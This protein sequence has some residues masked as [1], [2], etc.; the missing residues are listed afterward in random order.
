MKIKRTIL[1]YLARNLLT[2]V[3]VDDLLRIE[4]G[5]VFIGK[6][7]LTREEIGKLKTEAKMWE[8]SLLWQLMRSNVYWIANFK[9]MKGADQEIDMVMGRAM[10][11][12]IHILEEFINKL[13][14]V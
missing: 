8:S 9:M 3:D 5:K 13:K 4:N 6:K 12:N 10:T 1:K 11:A 2:M 14:I 7:E